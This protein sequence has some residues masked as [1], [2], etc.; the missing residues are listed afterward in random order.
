MPPQGAHELP[1]RVIVRG[2]LPGVALALQSGRDELVMP[3]STSD[4]QVT[5][6]LTA[7]V[8][9]PEG[10]G[11]MGFHGPFIRGP[12]RERFVH[13]TMGKRAGQPESCWDR[14]AKVPL[15]AIAVAQ[16]REALR[17]GGMLAVSFEGRGR[18]GGPT[19]A[20]VKLPAGPWMVRRAG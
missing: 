9:L 5:F 4:T 1:L 3:A 8:D 12:P 20:S 17:T 6:D 14:R 7:R 11:P 15:A 19:C 13:I 2:P 10:D 16:V 18:G